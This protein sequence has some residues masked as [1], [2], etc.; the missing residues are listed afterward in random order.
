M[1][2]CTYEAA[3][4]PFGRFGGGRGTSCEGATSGGEVVISVVGGDSVVGKLGSVKR[5]EDSSA[6]VRTL[7]QLL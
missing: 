4:C 1:I 5:L 3:C 6:Q 2:A 7:I